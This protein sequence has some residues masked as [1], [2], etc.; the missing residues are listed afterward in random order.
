M[1]QYTLKEWIMISRVLHR[2][3]KN[4]SHFFPRII[5]LDMGN[6]TGVVQVNIYL[7]G[8]SLGGSFLLFL[9]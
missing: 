3:P 6:T 4:T 2:I 7:Q 9:G 8:E 5:R 1:A